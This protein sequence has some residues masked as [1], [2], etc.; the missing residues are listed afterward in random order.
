MSERE[1]TSVPLRVLLALH[2]GGGAGSVNSTLALG[3]GLRARGVDARLVCPP[4]SPVEAE[5]RAGGLPV[6]PLPLA[7]QSRFMNARALG[8]LLRGQPVDIINS[9]GSRDREAFT[10]LGLTGRLPAPLILTRRSFPRS[11]RLQNWLAARVSA[12]V[13][14][15]S[16]SVRDE[17]AG[18]GTPRGKVVVV[19]SGFVASRMDRPV[20]N[21]ERDAWRGRIGWEPSRRVIGVVAR[22]KDQAVVL[23]ALAH[24]ATP[25]RLVLAGLD[26]AALAAPLPPVPERHAVVRLPFEPAIRPLYDLLE[27][28]LHPSRWDAF[29]QAVLEALALGLPVV[30]SDATGNAEIIRHEADG[31]LVAPTDPAAWAAAI[32]HL[33][34][35]PALAA[36]L[37]AAGRR[38][39][40]EDFSLDR[41]LDRTLAVY[42]AV[43]AE[44]ALRR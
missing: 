24:V 17:L 6:H 38:R 21:A 4:D 11:T 35:D 43:L 41:M 34:G 9:Q 16:E 37:G 40:R 2:Q 3:L 10:W 31:L 33:L 25:V 12:R 20:S 1:D 30:A 18:R 7:R 23:A 14:A 19:P 29:P 27:L 39:A 28:A 42:H 26:A 5:A 13:I 32:D 8:A 44:R 22:P 36:R 15:L